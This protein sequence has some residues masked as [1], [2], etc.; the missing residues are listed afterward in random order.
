V[1]VDGRIAHETCLVGLENIASNKNQDGTASTPV[2]W[3]MING[4]FPV[5]LNGTPA[6][7][8]AGLGDS[9]NAIIKVK[10]A[11]RGLW[12]VFSPCSIFHSN[13]SGATLDFISSLGDE[14][15]SEKVRLCR[16]SFYLPTTD[17]GGYFF[18]SAFGVEVSLAAATS[19]SSLVY[20]ANSNL[21][22]SYVEFY[23]VT[24]PKLQ[25]R[26]LLN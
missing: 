19:R 3:R 16:N 25:Y 26:E 1:E 6:W 2:T 15:Y 7:D 20:L 10:R 5:R 4:F 22:S 18:G 24:H 12:T 11:G 8:N 23:D 17:T 14:S 21:T 9:T 13:G